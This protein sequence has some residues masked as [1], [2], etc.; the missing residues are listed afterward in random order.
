MSVTWQCT[1]CE[2]YI[3]AKE[4]DDDSTEWNT[5][6]RMRESLIWIMLVVKFPPKGSWAISDDNW[7]EIYTRINMF[8]TAR[9]AYRSNTNM[10]A[11]IIDIFF[12]PA[13]IFSMIN[14][15]V[16][17]GHQT[18]LQFAKDLADRMRDD[19][20]RDIGKFERQYEEQAV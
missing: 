17:A 15:Q 8:E 20:E 2:A 4:F 14:L 1:D 13:E 5:F 7:K 16:N 3:K 10:D 11:D 12:T 9:G 18:S 6:A 19:A